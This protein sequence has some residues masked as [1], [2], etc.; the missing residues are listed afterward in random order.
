MTDLLQGVFS[1]GEF[2]KDKRSGGKISLSDYDQTFTLWQSQSFMNISGKG[3][4]KA[5]NSFLVG[6]EPGEKETAV[7]VVVHDELEVALGKVKVKKTGS[8]GG[9]NGLTSIIQQ[10]QTKVGAGHNLIQLEDVKDLDVNMFMTGLL[11]DRCWYWKAGIKGPRNSQQMGSWKDETS[12]TEGSRG[13]IATIGGRRAEEDCQ[14]PVREN[15]HLIVDMYDY[16]K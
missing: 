8:A 2:S 10:L 12:G 15:T 3:V 14:A 5:W 4:Q 6:L 7:L 9:H 16:C 11:P 13:E 1:S